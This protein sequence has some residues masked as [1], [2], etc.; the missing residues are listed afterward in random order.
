M[1]STAPSASYLSWGIKDSFRDYL[2]RLADF[3]L[4]VEEGAF[5][6]AGNAVCFPLDANA[7]DGAD[8]IVWAGLGHA[9]FCA[10]GGMMRLS[11]K[12]PVVKQN[13]EEQV[14][15]FELGSATDTDESDY[16]DV[17]RLEE[18]PD[19][20]SERRTL[21]TFLLPGATS[22]FND[23]YDPHTELDPVIIAPGND[24]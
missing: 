19:E 13:S 17:A 6:G 12:N 8:D 3:S 4:N 9:V 2:S 14:L 20:D 10:H 7:T 21:R 5:V 24:A 15:A 1:I 22:L 18:S 23:M 16:F 11:L